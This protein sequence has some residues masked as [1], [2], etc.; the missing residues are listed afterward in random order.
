VGPAPGLGP[1]LF[2]GQGGIGSTIEQEFRHPPTWPPSRVAWSRTRVPPRLCQRRDRAAIRLPRWRLRIRRCAAPSCRARWW[3]RRALR[4][5]RVAPPVPIPAAGSAANACGGCT[6]TPRHV[7]V[8]AG[9]VGDRQTR[10]AGLVV[11]HRFVES[12]G[13]PGLDGSQ[14][15]VRRGRGR[16]GRW[17]GPIRDA[18]DAPEFRC[19]RLAERTAAGF[20]LPSRGARPDR[21]VRGRRLWRW[22]YR[23]Q[24]GVPSQWPKDARRVRAGVSPPEWPPRT[25]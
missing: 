18:T 9:S 24:A 23:R 2:V 4:D 25:A 1:G 6:S 11:M 10:Q 3:S 12:D 22:V 21:R 20:A 7:A 19:F 14:E 8:D 17:R 5:P 13:V 16:P 15:S